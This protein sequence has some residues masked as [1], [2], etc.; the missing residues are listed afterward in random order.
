LLFLKN[1]LNFFDIDETYGIVK[2]IVKDLVADREFL[3]VAV[4]LFKFYVK[5]FF[6]IIKYIERVRHSIKYL[7]LI[8][9]FF[10]N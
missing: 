10:G 8:E 9:N 4:K 7:L 3:F 5:S 1:L 2:K 6:D